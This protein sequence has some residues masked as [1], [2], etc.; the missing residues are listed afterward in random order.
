MTRWLG[1][2]MWGVHFIGIMLLLG[3]GIT[4]YFLLRYPHRGL[5]N[6]LDVHEFGKLEGGLEGLIEVIVVADHIEDPVDELRKAVKLNFER[7]VVYHFLISKDRAQDELDG[8]YRIFEALALIISKKLK[9]SVEDLVKI[10]QLSFDW[11]EVPYVFYKIINPQ[12][13]PNIRY[14]SLRGNQ[15]REGIADYYSYVAPRE[16][17]L[18]A[19][20]ILAEA[21]SRI[22]VTTEQIAD[23]NVVD[24]DMTRRSK[25]KA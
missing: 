10:E 3:I 7:G 2:I 22:V 23:S 11:N 18:F 8:Y 24:F 16:A 5:K 20:S 25:E 14:I 12:Q 9:H 4:S 17:D 1:S 19:R 13:T 21:P 6:I 15:K